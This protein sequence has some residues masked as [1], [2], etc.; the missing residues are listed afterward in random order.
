MFTTTLTVANK[1]AQYVTLTD[2]EGSRPEGYNFRVPFY[3]RGPENA[4][5]LFT[6]VQHPTELHN[7]YELILG[8]WGNRR[9]LLRKRINGAILADVY[10]PNVISEWKR[11][12]FIFQISKEGDI[13]LYS[14]DNPYKPLL[15]AFDPEP[16]QIEFISFKNHLTE[17]IEFFWG[18]NPDLPLDKV[19]QG[20]LDEN[21]GK[22][23]ISPLFTN[24]DKVKPV[25]DTKCKYTELI[26]ILNVKN[27]LVTCKFDQYIY[28]IFLQI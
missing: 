4:H 7:A 12:K 6:S 25:L 3:V 21:F 5:V 13:Y 24:W 14:E 2:I 20:I 18:N 19:V 16:A 1:Y 28:S 10:W 17:K 11:K 9:I 8:G 23:T 22:V 26:F 15:T 27:I